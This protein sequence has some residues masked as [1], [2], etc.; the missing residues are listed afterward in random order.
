MIDIHCHILPGV[1]DGPETLDEAAEMCRMAAAD[2]IDTI[3]ATPHFVSGATKWSEEDRAGWIEQLEAGLQK[4]R[5]EVRI[6]PGADVSIFPELPGFLR[7]G[8]LLTINKNGRYILAE[9]PFDSAPPNWDAFLLKLLE[10]GTVPIITHPERN[11]WF[12]RH[13]E[14]IYRIVEL[15]GMVQ[16]TA[17][18][19]TG[20]FGDE[21]RRFSAFL[22]KHNLAHVIATDAHSLTGRPPKL[23]EA[24][25]AASEVIG[26]ERARAMVTSIP[27]AIIEGRPVLLPEPLERTR[28]KGE[29]FKK[30]FRLM[31]QT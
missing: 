4:K 28:E 30:M 15:G 16:L 2:G 21:E 26:E 24:V 23:S 20:G 13:P 5:I 19:I 31:A 7:T 11:G 25:K 18:S 14:A 27:A 8:T 17:M 29:W 12:L 22:L 10:S 9:F 3:V 6:L 1:D